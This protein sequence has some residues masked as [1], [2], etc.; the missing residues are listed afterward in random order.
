MC[1]SVLWC[2]PVSFS[3]CLQETEESHADLADVQKAE[4]N[5]KEVAD[6]IN[7]AKRRKELGE[8]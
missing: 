7:E 3:Y 2:T 6:A 1:T 8:L 5:M 4:G